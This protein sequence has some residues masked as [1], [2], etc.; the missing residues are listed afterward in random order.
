[1]HKT[2][3]VLYKRSGG[4]LSELH[5][6]A[7]HRWAG[8]LARAT[9]GI[10]QMAVRTRCMAWWRFVQHPVFALH[11]KRFGQ[12]SRCE[13]ALEKFYGVADDDDPI[14]RNVGWMA[15]AQDRHSRKTDEASLASSK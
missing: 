12:P 15:L 14:E 10:L 11:P 7:Y 2:R 3:H 8:L 6:R 9:A 13:S 1:M 5:D 4:S